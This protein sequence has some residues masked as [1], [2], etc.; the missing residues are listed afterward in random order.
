MSTDPTFV[1]RY[2]PWALVAGASEGLGAAWADALARRGLKLLLLARRPELLEAT[3]KA[4][5][6]RH[7]VEVV[8]QAFDLASPSLEGPL[9][10]L[11]AG[12]EVGLLVYNAA[13]P[14]QGPFLE[15]P[16]E[17]QLRAL[18]VNC[19][20]PL[21][22]AH[23][24]GRAMAQRGRGGIVLMSS[25]TAFNGSPFLSTYGATKAFNLVL[26]EG[27][28]FELQARGV[29]VLACCAGATRTPNLLRTSPQ[30]EPG[31]IEPAQVV[32]EALAALGRSGAMVP[33]AFNRLAS[34][35]M[36]RLLPRALAISILGK[37]TSA[38][39]LPP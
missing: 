11:V 29:D 18:D 2:G 7:G 31:M 14:A 30:G 34:F 22:L 5:R 16:L 24:L 20:A 1:D 3:A 26:A 9:T 12:R 27:L 38:L 10:A 15:Q 39:R 32:E 13:F 17:N 33:G 28:W 19:R 8:T 36:R 25:L 37:R 4:L 6:E 23:G 35:A 21:T